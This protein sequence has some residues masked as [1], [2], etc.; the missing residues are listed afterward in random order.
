MASLFHGVRILEISN[1]SSGQRIDNFLKRELK[2]VPRSYI[3]RI[4]RRGEVRVNGGRVRPDRRLQPGDRVRIP[5]VRL[6]ESTGTPTIPSDVQASLLGRV[7]LETHDLM[8]INKPAGLAV[9]SG[10]SV[11][12]GLI[13]AMRAARPDVPRIELVHRLDRE[14]SGCLV[15]AKEPAALRAMHAALRT[16]NA[17]KRYLALLRGKGDAIPGTVRMPLRRY[18]VTGGERKVEVSANGR[19]ATTHFRILSEYAFSS[20]VEVSIETGRTHQIR[21]H[22]ASAGTPVGGD[23]KYGDREFNRRLRDVGLCRLFLHAHAI[24]IEVGAREVHATAPLEPELGLVLD[25]L[26]GGP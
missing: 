2:G 3:Y 10:S 18:A 11:K 9:H 7:L 16:G 21:A 22:A 12:W 23:S 14:T 8:V 15:L 6:A 26:G 24:S 4:L 25:R 13:E 19:H 17:Q 5:P 20:F 1:D